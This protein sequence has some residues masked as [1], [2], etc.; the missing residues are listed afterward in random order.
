VCITGAYEHVIGSGYSGNY[1]ELGF[2]LGVVP[3]DIYGMGTKTA[4]F[5]FDDLIEKL[6]LDLFGIP[7]PDD[8][9]YKC[10]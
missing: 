10:E 5:N 9:F 3:V 8:N 7:L 2:G 6:I 1:F 4:V